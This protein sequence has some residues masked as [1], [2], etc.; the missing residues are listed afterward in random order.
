MFQRKTFRCRNIISFS[1]IIKQFK[2]DLSGGIVEPEPLIIDTGSVAEVKETGKTIRLLN[3]DPCL[4]SKGSIQLKVV[5]HGHILVFAAEI[6]HVCTAALNNLRRVIFRLKSN[7]GIGIVTGFVK[8]ADMNIIEA[9][10][11]V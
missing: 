6:E 9:C 1:I 5:L 10:S 4:E 7:C 11:K 3:I 2:F 8:G